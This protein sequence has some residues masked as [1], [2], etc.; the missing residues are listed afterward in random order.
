MTVTDAESHNIAAQEAQIRKHVEAFHEYLRARNDGQA[1]EALKAASE[2]A[3][4]VFR[5]SARRRA[6]EQV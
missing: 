6:L 3:V 2:A 4:K 5:E 1:V